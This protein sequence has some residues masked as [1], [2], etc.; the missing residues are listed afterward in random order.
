[1]L[2]DVWYFDKINCRDFP[3][4]KIFVKH[5]CK[6]NVVLY[7][8]YTAQKSLALWNKNCEIKYL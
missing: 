4:S 8:Q 3:A 2:C 5:F 7:I 6:E 1:M